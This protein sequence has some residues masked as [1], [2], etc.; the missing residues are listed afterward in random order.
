MEEI[1]NYPTPDPALDQPPAADVH[2]P[3]W[4]E[5]ELHADDTNRPVTVEYVPIWYN[6]RTNSPET[7]KWVA[8]VGRG[9]ACADHRN[10]GSRGDECRR[11]HPV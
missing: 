3:S 5:G 11:K 4:W 9:A 8:V 2:V 10:V 6:P 1:R 7:Y